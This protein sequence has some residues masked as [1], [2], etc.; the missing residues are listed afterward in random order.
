MKRRQKTDNK[1]DTIMKRAIVFPGSRLETIRSSLHCYMKCPSKMNSNIIWWDTQNDKQC[2]YFQQCIIY[3]IY[4]HNLTWVAHAAVSV[5]RLRMSKPEHGWR[6][7]FKALLE[8]PSAQPDSRQYK[9]NNWSVSHHI[10]PTMFFT[11]PQSKDGN[12]SDTSSHSPPPLCSVSWG[13]LTDPP[14]S[15]G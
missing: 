15:W 7:D 12:N 1:D 5:I 3:T 10:E 14:T 11:E 6:D 8:S 4:V 9:Q 13:V 2:L